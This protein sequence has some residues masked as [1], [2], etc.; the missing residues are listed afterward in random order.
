MVA[1]DELDVCASPG[2]GNGYD[3][4]EGIEA[5]LD[6]LFKGTVVPVRGV[7]VMGAERLEV[8]QVTNVNYLVKGKGSFVQIIREAV[9]AIQ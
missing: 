5:S 8:P 4:V 1:F 2:V 6:V 3:L 9:E 7:H